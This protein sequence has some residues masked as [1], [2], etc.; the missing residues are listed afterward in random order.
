MSGKIIFIPGGTSCLDSRK[1]V[2]E[3][4]KDG[5]NTAYKD[6]NYEPLLK[7]ADIIE[8]MAKEQYEHFKK[9]EPTK[10]DYQSLSAELAS[11]KRLEKE[12]KGF[13]K[14]DKIFLFSTHTDNGNISQKVNKLA[15]DRYLGPKTSVEFE[16]IEDL[17]IT[18]DKFFDGIS[19][20]L[21][22]IGEIFRKEY[23]YNPDNEFYFNVTAGYKGLIPLFSLMGFALGL[24]IFY[25]FEGSEQLI[26][27]PDDV[28]KINIQA[29]LSPH[30][31]MES[32]RA[33]VEIQ[34]TKKERK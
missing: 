3:K 20:A 15:L 7:R 14:K 27:I 30:P 1:Y 17:K 11:L 32:F 19:N 12:I 10:S 5:L 22:K 18:G 33:I 26:I 16:Q 31:L 2:D 34:E 23:K 4:V 24:K 9:S 8:E 21:K 13:S 29:P 6:D 28:L 25:L